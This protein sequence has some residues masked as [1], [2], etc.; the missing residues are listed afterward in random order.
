VKAVAVV[1]VPVAHQHL[2]L[3]ELPQRLLSQFLDSCRHN[4]SFL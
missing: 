3:F 4:A 2:D 1:E